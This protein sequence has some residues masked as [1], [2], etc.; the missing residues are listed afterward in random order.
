MGLR[1][2]DASSSKVSRA[3]VMM[4]FRAQKWNTHI[5]VHSFLT[6]HFERQSLAFLLMHSLWVYKTRA[7]S[8]PTD[9]HHLH[10]EVDAEDDNVSLFKDEKGRRLFHILYHH[11]VLSLSWHFCFSCISLAMEGDAFHAVMLRWD[12]LVF[13]LISLLQTLNCPSF[14]LALVSVP[15]TRDP[16]HRLDCKSRD[17]EEKTRIIDR[18]GSGNTVKWGRKAFESIPRHTSI[19]SP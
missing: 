12:H 19:V 5:F 15:Q 4:A 16:N 2:L 3:C 9:H 13:C 6:I 8:S 11:F 14:S 17:L 10:D 1:F 7:S 18:E